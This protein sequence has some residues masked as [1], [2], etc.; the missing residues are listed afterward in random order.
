VSRTQRLFEL[1]QILRRHRYPISGQQL[2]D[3]LCVSL[4]TVYRDIATL[5]TQGAEILGEPD[6]GYVLRLNFL[7]RSM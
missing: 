4:R 3:E 2:A 1:I 5:Q 6:Q 7:K